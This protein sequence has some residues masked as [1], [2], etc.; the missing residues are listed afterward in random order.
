LARAFFLDKSGEPGSMDRYG[1][2]GVKVGPKVAVKVI[3]K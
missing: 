1:D 2:G 3:M